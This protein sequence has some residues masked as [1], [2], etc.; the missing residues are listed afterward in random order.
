ML[1]LLLPFLLWSVLVVALYGAAYAKFAG[2]QD[3]ITAVKLGYRS[4]VHA[5]R[6]VFYTGEVALDGVSAQGGFFG[7]QARARPRASHLKLGTRQPAGA[8]AVVGSSYTHVSLRAAGD[9]RIHRLRPA[10]RC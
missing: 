8:F 4:Q 9:V 5:S 2:V 3:S 1:R 10:Q 6:V 7:L